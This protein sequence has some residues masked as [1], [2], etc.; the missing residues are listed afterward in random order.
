MF[1]VTSSCPHPNCEYEIPVIFVLCHCFCLE[2][3]S[4]FHSLLLKLL[5]VNITESWMSTTVPFMKANYMTSVAEMLHL[6]FWLVLQQRAEKL[7]LLNPFHP[8]ILLHKFICAISSRG[9]PRIYPELRG[10]FTDTKTPKLPL[11]VHLVL[12]Q[13]K[14]NQSGSR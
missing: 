8:L 9:A 3:L 4:I 7:L 14:I 13:L 2:I 12:I 1:L 11:W 10:F 5:M 6:S